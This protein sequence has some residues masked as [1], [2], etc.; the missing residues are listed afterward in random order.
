VTITATEALEAN[1]GTADAEQGCTNTDQAASTSLV[2]LK[3]H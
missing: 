1:T 2:S 3:R